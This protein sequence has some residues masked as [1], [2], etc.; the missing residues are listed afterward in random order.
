MRGTCETCEQVREVFQPT[1]HTHLVCPECYVNVGIAIQLYD[2]LREVE[3]K[4]IQS[5]ELEAELKRVLQKLF[6]RIPGGAKRGL[7]GH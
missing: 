1:G 4:G 7:G 6:G 2:T 5:L 3:R